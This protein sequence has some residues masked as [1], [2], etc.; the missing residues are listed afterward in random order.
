VECK[1]RPIGFDANILVELRRGCMSRCTTFER[2]FRNIAAQGA[3]DSFGVTPGRTAN[4]FYSILKTRIGSSRDAR[5]AGTMQAMAAEA[6]SNA[7][8]PA[9]TPGSSGWVS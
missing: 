4:S 9:N 2:V 6:I 1:R 8:T 5:H 7:A 3:E